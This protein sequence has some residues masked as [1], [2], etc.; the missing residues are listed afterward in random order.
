MASGTST[1]DFGLTRQLVPLSQ[2]GNLMQP[3]SG[4]FL[5]QV[6]RPVGGRPKI[7]N[8]QHSMKQ[9]IPQASIKGVH[10]PLAGS[11]RIP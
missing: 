6:P 7:A 3:K 1:D 5:R 9:K 8:E 10:S 4:G 2:D 11:V